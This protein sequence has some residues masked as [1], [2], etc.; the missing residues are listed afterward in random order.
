MFKKPFKI[1]NPVFEHWAEFLH[2][3]LF[4][5]DGTKKERVGVQTHI[6]DEMVEK[7]GSEFSNV[8]G[9]SKLQEI[10]TQRRD[11][12]ALLDSRPRKCTLVHAFLER[13]NDALQVD[14]LRK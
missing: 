11:L 4:D 6:Y 3:K 14:D 12:V 2:S 1:Q 5:E 8:C 13:A 10:A 9:K 7:Y